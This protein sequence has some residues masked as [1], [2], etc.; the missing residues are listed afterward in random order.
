[1]LRLHPAWCLA[2]VTRA[3][4]WLG[5]GQIFNNKRNVDTHSYSM[6]IKA[7][8]KKLH[9]LSSITLHTTVA[10]KS[11]K[12]H[13]V[14]S[15]HVRTMTIRGHE[16]SGEVCIFITRVRL[17]LSRDKI[18]LEVDRTK[19]IFQVEETHGAKLHLV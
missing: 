17:S 7:V 15:R 13:N 9:D 6:L 4:W 19:N 11:P 8:S 14:A 2:V 18:Q 1:M 12:F 3:G 5:F 16:V 10:Q